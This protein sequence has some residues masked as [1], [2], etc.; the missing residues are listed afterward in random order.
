MKIYVCSSNG[1][2]FTMNKLIFYCP[3]RQEL[4]ILRIS[5]RIATVMSIFQRHPFG[6]FTITTNHL[7][8]NLFILGSYREVRAY[9]YFYE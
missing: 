1:L 6:Q 7:Q 8:L 9:I 5:W 3:N 2:Y 4:V